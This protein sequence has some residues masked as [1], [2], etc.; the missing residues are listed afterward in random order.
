MAVT[1]AAASG[2][3]EITP[4]MIEAGKQALCGVSLVDD[5]WSSVV[6]AI[7]G[8]MQNSCKVQGG[9]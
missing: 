5:D 8:A 7:Y 4:E 6:I 9:R 1:P 3:I 2:E